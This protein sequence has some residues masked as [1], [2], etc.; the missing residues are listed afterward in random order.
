M[1][2]LAASN[3]LMAWKAFDHIPM[4]GSISIADLAKAVEAQESLVG[5]YSLPP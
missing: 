4:G 1:A 3:L 5:L 2:D